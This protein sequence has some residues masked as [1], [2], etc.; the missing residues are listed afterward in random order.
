[1]TTRVLLAGTGTGGHVQHHQRDM[2]LPAVQALAADGDPV[3]V[4]GVL[5]T[6]DGDGRAAA[7]AQQAG[8]PVVADLDALPDPVQLLIACPDVNRPDEFAALLQQCAERSI[9]VILDKPTLLPTDLLTYLAARFPGVVAGHHARVHPAVVTARGRVAGGSLGLL[10]AIHGELL[11]GAGDGPHPLGEL[12]NLAIYSLDVVQSLIGELHGTAHAVISPPGPD[13][14]GESITVSLRCRPDV[15][16]TLLIGRA[17]GESTQGGLHRYRILGSH[18]QLLVDLDSPAFDLIGAPSTRL[19]FGPNSVDAL[20]DSVI[21][22]SRQP[23]LGVAARLAV[24]LDALQE[25]AGSRQAL[26]F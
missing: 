13:G 21:R 25:S 1:M 20:V 16:V 6:A 19:P 9:P 5:A 15:V 14:C 10:H 17:G 22:G 4:V 3:E 23:D 11:C 8:V 18:G 12:R 26:D 24:V 7:L 2:Y